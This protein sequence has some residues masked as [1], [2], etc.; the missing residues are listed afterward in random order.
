M[1]E[2]SIVNSNKSVII[3]GGGVIG[4]FTAYHLANDGWEVTVIERHP[5][6]TD[7]CVQGSAGY[8]SPS[9]VIPLSAPGM[10]WTGLKW[11][12]SSRSPFYIQ[13]RLDLDLIRWGLLFARHCNP[14][15]LRRAAPILRDLCLEGRKGFLQFAERS[16]NTFDL[17]TEG[18]LCLCRTQEG[19]DHETHGL[20]VL[21]NELDRKSVV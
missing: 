14:A 6:G 17:R 1:L 2:R 16:G 12:L 5:E 10:I 11:M 21:A 18:L 9:H 19:L 13:P 3:C 7:S 15:H 20:A 4:L 8:L